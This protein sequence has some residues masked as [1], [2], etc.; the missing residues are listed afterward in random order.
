MTSQF[1]HPP[2][3]PYIQLPYVPRPA[4]PGADP[5]YPWH[6]CSRLNEKFRLKDLNRHGYID[7]NDP[8]I[9]VSP[10][11]VEVDYDRKKYY[12]PATAHNEPIH[13]IFKPQNWPDLDAYQYEKL[14][15]ALR[16]A[17]N[18]LFEPSVMVFFA[19]YF[20]EPRCPVNVHPR[21][22]LEKGLMYRFGPGTPKP[23]NPI[24]DDE[25]KM[26]CQ[27]L[28]D[29]QDRIVWGFRPLGGMFFA[30]TEYYDDNSG[31]PNQ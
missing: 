22:T 7:Y 14:Q 15:P 5:S 11:S 9:P 12:L 16:L 4:P 10:R 8:P 21:F 6:G 13:P 30:Q 29:V 24:S 18:I 25:M 17:L 19:Q 23:G 27:K 1:P 28:L 2:L 31:G 26:A 3:K 20:R